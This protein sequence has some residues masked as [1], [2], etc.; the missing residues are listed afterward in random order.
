MKAKT[1]PKNVEERLASETEHFYYYDTY[2][3]GKRDPYKSF[4]KL[5]EP[6]W[7]VDASHRVLANHCGIII[8]RETADQLEDVF[9][10]VEKYYYM[11]YLS[12]HD[13][14]EA[15]KW[16]LGPIASISSK[17]LCPIPQI[18]PAYRLGEFVD[19]LVGEKFP[20]HFAKEI[21]DR[22]LYN[23]GLSLN[24]IIADPKYTPVDTSIIDAAVAA[25]MATNPE[26][27]EEAKVNPK[28][29]QWF[30]GQVLKANRGMSP[31]LVKEALE[32]VMS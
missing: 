13:Y 1:S 5:K 9:P 28:L 31:V 17:T 7:F 29:I 26:K 16:I 21:F 32:K 24:Q 6:L 10:G 12:T 20:K 30:V 15:I 4:M 2:I 25:V 11:Y 19:A 27:V 23:D 8:D 14:N 18:C 3:D 22:V